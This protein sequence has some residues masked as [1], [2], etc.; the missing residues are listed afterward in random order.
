MQKARCRAGRGMNKILQCSVQVKTR[1]KEGMRSAMSASLHKSADSAKTPNAIIK[2]IFCRKN[3][4]KETY[5]DVMCYRPGAEDVRI[6]RMVAY[7]TGRK[8]IVD[9]GEEQSVN[10]AHVEVSFPCDINRNFYDNK[11]TMGFSIMQGSTVYFRLKSWREEYS[12]IRIYIDFVLYVKLFQ[13]CALLALEAI[14]FDQIAMYGAVFLPTDVLNTRTR[15]KHGTYCSKIITEVLQQFGIGGPLL[16][17]SIP[18]HSTPSML[19]LYLKNGG[20]LHAARLA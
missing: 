2:D 13:T 1:Q 4:G 16:M 15:Y 18:C 19:Y 9:S 14:R 5:V 6:N 11:K 17:A 10:F 7:A 12:A 20:A 3:Q 8:E